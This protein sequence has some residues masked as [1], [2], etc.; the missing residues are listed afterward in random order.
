MKNSMYLLTALLLGAVVF[1]SQS[2]AMDEEDLRSRF[3]SSQPGGK[4]MQHDIRLTAHVEIINSTD[5]Q[6]KGQRFSWM[7]NGP[8]P[9]DY[10]SALTQ[11]IL[12][13]L[14]DCPENIRAILEKDHCILAFN[15][16]IGGTIHGPVLGQS[17]FPVNDSTGKKGRCVTITDKN[18]LPT[19]I[20]W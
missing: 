13:A 3:L 17:G 15:F 4:V 14:P 7:F 2:S 16:D 11:P 12:T 19:D 20:F 18:E 1:S 8:L 6:K 9:Y 5:E 10:A